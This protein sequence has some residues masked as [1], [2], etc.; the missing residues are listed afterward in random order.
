M[1][2]YAVTNKTDKEVWITIYEP[3]GFHHKL[4]PGQVGRDLDLQQGR[5][6]NRFD[7]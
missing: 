4:R 1:A 2:G 7:L 5:L 3:F 6:G